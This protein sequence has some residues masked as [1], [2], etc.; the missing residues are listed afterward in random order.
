VP[1]SIDRRAFLRGSAG[2]VGGALAAERVA[3]TARHAFG[4]PV[5]V[6]APARTV[7][8]G[9]A[10]FVQKW[11]IAAPAIALTTF[12]RFLTNKIFNCRVSGSPRVYALDLGVAGGRLTPGPNPYAHADWVMSEEDWIGVL[13]GEYSGLAP[14]VSGRTW[15]TRDE[16]N[17][18]T[19]LGILM[20]V[21]AFLPPSLRPDPDILARN[22]QSILRVGIPSCEAEFDTFHALDDLRADPAGEA[23]A[24]VLPRAESV[25]VTRILCEWF[26]NLSYRDLPRGTLENA[27]E[28]LTSILATLYA[29]S[30]MGPGRRMARAVRSFGERGPSSV[31]GVTR[32]RTTPRNAAMVNSVLSQVLEWEDWTFIVHS[33]ASIVP[34]ALAVGEAVGASGRQVLTAIVAAN[35]FL[36]R[37]GPVLSDVV[38]TGNTVAVHQI[39]TTL[40]AG[41]LLGLGAGTLR[42]ALGIACAQPQVTSLAAWTADAKGML[43]GWPAFTGVTAAY[44]AREGVSGNRDIVEA[45]FGYAYRVADVGDPRRLEL[46]VRDLG[47]EWRFDRSRNELFTK[48]YPTDGFQLTSVAAVLDIVHRLGKKEFRGIRRRDLADAIDSISIRIPWVMAATASMYSSNRDDLYDRVGRE[49]GWEYIPLLFDGRYP[50][51]AAIADGELTHR[52]YA[53]DRLRDPVIRALIRKIDEVP[54]LLMGVFGA[55]AKITLA[56][57]PSWTSFKECIDEFPVAEKLAAGAEGVRSDRQVAALLSAIDGFDGFDDVRSFTRLL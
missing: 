18:I 51:A 12:S 52:Q 13:F 17:R 36:A 29:G 2:L 9:L 4:E 33:G 20:Y 45:P 25:G 57:G 46:L 40:V 54:D 34:V 22:L 41:K 49:P 7:E 50:I 11:E 44:L 31:I 47:R 8:G 1:G 16:A 19:L 39:E 56:G 32:Y 48:R 5:E 15:P 14:I 23:V 30:Q 55:E 37:A 35:E 3:F 27:R 53:D 21:F 42:S 38:H 28:Q 10:S 6:P 26:A 43:S 24:R